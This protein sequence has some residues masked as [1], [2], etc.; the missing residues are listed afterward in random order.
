[1]TQE[2]RNAFTL[3]IEQVQAASD[4]DFKTNYPNT[5]GTSLQPN[6]IY[7]EGT[8]RLKIIRQDASGKSVFCFVDIK[9]GDILKPATFHAPAKGARGNIFT[10]KKPLTGSAMY[11]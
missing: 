5:Y 6:F 2:F 1:M 7:T 9:N 10:D 11:R 4:E 3:Y 8:T